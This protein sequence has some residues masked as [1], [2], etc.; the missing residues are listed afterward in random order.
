MLSCSQN[1]WIIQNALQNTGNGIFE[2][3]NLIFFRES[4][5]PDNVVFELLR[6]P[7][8]LPVRTPSKLHRFRPFFA[9]GFQ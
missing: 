5:P 6:L 8:F 3:L 2:I 9:V 1:C 4:M 7:N